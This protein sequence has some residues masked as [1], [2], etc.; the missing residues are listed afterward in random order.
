[1]ALDA[2]QPVAKITK[3]RVG[4]NQEQITGKPTGE[5][6]EVQEFR[7]Q[8]SEG[9]SQESET[10]KSVDELSSKD[11]RKRNLHFNTFIVYVV[12]RRIL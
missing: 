6:E 5:G 4:E 8:K 12:L 2:T 3:G 10:K 1:V 9:R 7:N 11:P